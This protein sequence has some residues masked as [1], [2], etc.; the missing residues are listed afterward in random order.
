MRLID[1]DALMNTLQE[2]F[3]KREKEEIFTGSR[4]AFVTWND[5]ICHFKTAPTIDAVPVKHGEWLVLNI[6]DY[7][8]RPTGRK[9]G[10]CPFCGYLT[11]EFRRLLEAHHELTNYCPNCGAKMEGAIDNETD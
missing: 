1:A 9:V 2:L 4:G 10:N 7:A 11:G 8:Q 5:A 3:D 6:L